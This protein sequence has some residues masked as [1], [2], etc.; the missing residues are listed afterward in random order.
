MDYKSIFTFD[1]EWNYRSLGMLIFL[2]F[3]PNLLGLINMPTVFGF[4]IHIFQVAIFI[5]AV[6]YGP[7]GGLLSGLVGSTY[8]AFIMHNPYIIVGNMLLGFFVG[9]FARYK[10]HTVIAVILAYVIQLPWLILTDYYLV[11]LSAG[12][13]T[14]LVI[15]LAVSNIIWAVVAHYTALPLKRSLS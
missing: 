5:A 6:I 12:F 15:A 4:K 14:A 13:I 11:G 3:L 9:F 10:I 7:T 8:S 2:I 1:T